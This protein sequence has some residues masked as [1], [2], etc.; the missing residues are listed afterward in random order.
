MNMLH[1]EFGLRVFKP[2]NGETVRIETRLDMR[3]EVSEEVLER[4]ISL[5]PSPAKK[6]CPFEACLI[7]DKQ[8]PSSSI[9]SVMKYNVCRT[10]T[11][12]R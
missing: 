12:L 11:S 3:I 2:A 4:A 1:Q 7:M 5:D 8:V 10:A 6:R 9:V